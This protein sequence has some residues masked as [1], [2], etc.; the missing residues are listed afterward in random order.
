MLRKGDS[1]FLMTDS[2]ETV[3]QVMACRGRLA[4]IKWP[5]HPR[6]RTHRKDFLVQVLK[7]KTETKGGKK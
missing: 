2:D 3:G 7:L 5:G 1:V 4:D 6:V